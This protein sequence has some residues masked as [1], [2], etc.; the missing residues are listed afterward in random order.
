[1]ADLILDH[2]P[3][4]VSLAQQIRLVAGLRW[5]L[6]RN[7]LR[8]RNNRLDLIGMLFAGI[9]GAVLVFGLSFAFCNAAQQ[10]IVNGRAGW[11]ALLF[12]AI[13]VWWQVFPIFVAGFG[14]NF[15]FRA[16]LRFPLSR[17]AFYLIGLAYGLADF[18]SVAAV[19]WLAAMTLGVTTALPGLLPAMLLVCGIFLLLNVTMERMVGSWL[20]RLLARRRSRE[21]FLALFVAAMISLQFITPLLERY[22]TSAKPIFDRLLPYLA[23]LPPSLAGS[24]I[25]NFAGGNVGHAFAGLAGLLA[26]VVILSSILWLRFAAQYRG[27][28]LSETA[29]PTRAALPRASGRFVVPRRQAIDGLRVLPPRVA[30]ILRKEFRY[31]VRNGFS[32]VLLIVPPMMILLLTMQTNTYRHTHGAAAQGFSRSAFFPGVMGYLVLVLMGAGYNSFAY[33]GRGIQTYFMAPLLFRDVFLAKN[34]LLACIVGLE[35]ALSTIVFAYRVGLPETPVLVASLL[36]VMFTVIGQMTIANWSSLS[37]PRKIAFGQMRNQRQSGMA[38]LV[39]FGAQLILGGMSALLFFAGRWTGDR[40]LPAEAF[41][42]LAAAA[43]A[44]YVASLDPL[45]QLAE[46]KKESLIEVLSR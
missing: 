30:E 2:A 17:R 37:F 29:S 39:L 7:K 14:A 20:E 1:V 32:F 15:E 9:F 6:M 43:V 13:F 8:Q 10:F 24:A 5:R 21:L 40:W 22:G 35:V 33:E 25:A 31:L 28:E 45:S 34:L 19:C 42:F 26:Y 27:E 12:W 44:G 36:A 46:K 38:V 3:H 23:P 16:L 41:A 11:I 18:S 4:A